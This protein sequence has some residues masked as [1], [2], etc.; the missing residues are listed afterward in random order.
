MREN[1]SKLQKHQAMQCKLCY[2][3]FYDTLNTLVVKACHR[4]C[5]KL[6]NCMT[7]HYETR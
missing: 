2:G 5:H 3:H 7:F 4:A 1:T 6:L